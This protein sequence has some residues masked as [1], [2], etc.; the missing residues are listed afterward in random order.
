[1]RDPAASARTR[2]REDRGEEPSCRGGAS[3]DAGEELPTLLRTP[4]TP[5]TRR[6]MVKQLVSLMVS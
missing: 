4:R 3:G 2:T 6:M 1:M 5:E